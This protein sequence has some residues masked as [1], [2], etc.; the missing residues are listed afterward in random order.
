MA[1]AEP[2]V[3]I[4]RLNELLAERGVWQHGE[5]VAV[6]QER[7]G[8]DFG[9]SG[10]TYRLFV[11]TAGGTDATL[12]AKVE[13]TDKIRRAV[14][15][16]RHNEVAMAGWI[17]AMYGSSLE[18][19][20][21]DGV[22]LLEDIPD[23]TQGDDLLGCTRP[24]AED[25]IRIVARLHATT[26][27]ETGGAGVTERW[28][29]PAWE[30]GRW[31][32]RLAGVAARYP[33]AFTDAVVARLVSFDGEVAAAVHELGAGPVAW[34]HHDPH[35]DNMLWRADARP[36]LLDWSGAVQAP[37]SLDV[38][39]LLM[40]L[41]FRDDPPMQPAEVLALYRTTLEAH[42]VTPPPDQTHSAS[43]GLRPLMRGMAGW[44]GSTPAEPDTGRKLALRDAS[45]GRV[46]RALAWIDGQR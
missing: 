32:E 15:F 46:L 10:V 22:I 16:R 13:T 8:V 11:T 28:A 4:G 40:S 33:S 36:V 39:V 12:V 24:Q 23:A 20:D 5:V 34:V 26:W 17:P 18:H 3:E 2:V 41:A 1:R 29:T 45:V 7:I 30:P 44:A 21:G 42:D 38:A 14:E 31:N 19:G 25:L 9:L 43:L 6:R 37:P 35:P 27:E